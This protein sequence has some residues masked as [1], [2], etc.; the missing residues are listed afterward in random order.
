M[1]TE[2]EMTMVFK[3]QAGE[4][5]LVP[6]ETLTRGRVPQEQKAQIEQLMTEQRD[7]EGHALSAV[8]LARTAAVLVTGAYLV[9][10]EVGAFDAID[11]QNY[12]P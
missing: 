9:L 8:H 11:W 1:T 3:D 12:R 2:H 10:S 6:L 4:Y 7:V 5:Y